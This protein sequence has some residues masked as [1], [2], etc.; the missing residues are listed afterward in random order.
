MRR[1]VSLIQRVF[2]I[3][4]VAT[5]LNACATG[6]TTAELLT[7]IEPNT[8]VVLLKMEGNRLAL[9]SSLSW[10]E[11]VIRSTTTNEAFRLKNQTS[12]GSKRYVFIGQ[13][14]QDK[15]KIEEL[16]GF[17]TG[18]FTDWLINNT[19]STSTEENLGTFTVQD[20][21]VTDL[22]ILI[23]YMPIEN[24]RRKMQMTKV[25]S[26]L[27]LEA[28]LR[29]YVPEDA[30]RLI[31][32]PFLTWDIPSII[33]T[34]FLDKAQSNVLTTGKPHHA[35]DGT[36]WVGAELGQLL[37]RKSNGE[38]LSIDT[39]LKMP[40]FSVLSINKDTVLAGL[41]DGVILITGDQ[42]NWKDVSLPFG[43]TVV[44]LGRLSSGELVAIS[45][46]KGAIK[47]FTSPCCGQIKWNMLRE[48]P[49]ENTY[50][51]FAQV[52][53]KDIFFVGLKMKAFGSDITRYRYDAT[54]KVWSDGPSR[55]LQL[56]T[57][58][59]KDILCGG[60]FYSKDHGITWIKP[61]KPG[62]DMVCRDAKIMY[63]HKL[64][65]IGWSSSDFE[66]FRSQDGGVSWQKVGD[67]LPRYSGN[68]AL[69]LRQFVGYVEPLQK[70][71]H[72]LIKTH[73]GRI[74]GS[75]DDGIHWKL[76]REVSDAS[77]PLVTR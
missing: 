48:V 13:V 14:P 49:F 70:L 66:L 46:E 75:Q 77:S 60:D 74:Y 54:N 36:Y 63:D 22:G 32:K 33:D 17:F 71:G 42:K 72:L 40:V 27:E 15:Y 62:G 29:R 34:K 39:G 4:I 65:S 5:L 35:D 64:S 7:K 37:K 41:D 8:G 25:N 58:L 52:T 67:K 50:L 51:S 6:K 10:D 19:S 69:E 9:S 26:K 16:S 3:C 28:T 76:E 31:S 57:S 23:V 43:G 11:I 30:P 61:E 21:Q 47:I 59:D 20:G 24:D 73:D 2:L 53:P 68:I 12:F 1:D 18:L 38:W 44:E 55:N 56:R 45:K